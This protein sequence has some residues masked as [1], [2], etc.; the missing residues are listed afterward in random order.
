MDDTMKTISN[1]LR[2]L[3]LFHMEKALDAELGR[4][5]AE[6]LA[7]SLVVE[8]LLAIEVGARIEGR[9]ER[10]IRDARLPERKLLEDF[11]FAFQNGQVKSC[12]PP[13][14]CRR[15]QGVILAET[16]GRAPHRQSAACSDAQ[17]LPSRYTPPRHAAILWVRFATAPLSAAQTIQD[18]T[19]SLSTRSGSTG[20]N[21]VETKPPFLQVIDAA[22]AGFHNSTNISFTERAT[23]WRPR[24]YHV[25]R[26]SNDPSFHNYQH[27]W[28][29]W[30]MFES[31]KLNRRQ[32]PALPGR[33]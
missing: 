24:H 32:K 18:R 21:R 15:K 4:A 16:P 12:L 13:W 29:S 23:T 22:T 33:S 20:S 27:K 5:A 8:R 17:T 6:G 25:P 3:K 10:R 26:G 2:M 31:S 11:D 28:T 9:I 19:S 14:V 30:R 7:A 1:Y